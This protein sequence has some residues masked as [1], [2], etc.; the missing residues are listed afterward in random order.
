MCERDAFVVGLSLLATAA[1]TAG[2]PQLEAVS[3][4]LPDLDG[5]VQ[6]GGDIAWCLSSRAVVP[7]DGVDLENTD[8]IRSVAVLVFKRERSRK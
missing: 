2:A 3:S 7:V 6:V 8:V 5:A 4:P 1:S